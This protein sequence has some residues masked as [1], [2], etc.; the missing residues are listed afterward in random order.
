MS[1]NKLRKITLKM[2]LFR[3][4]LP[5]SLIFVMIITIKAVNHRKKLTSQGIIV[6]LLNSKE[7]S[8]INESD[9]Y[10]KIT[11]FEPGLLLGENTSDIN[12]EL[13]ELF[14]KE[15]ESIQKAEV[16]IDAQNRI[17]VNIVS[18]E[19]IVRILP[20][21]GESY[22]MDAK[23]SKIPLSKLY[24]TRVPVVTGHIDPHFDG[25]I[26]YEQHNLKLVFALVQ[27]IT[28]DEFLSSM[29]EQIHIENNGDFILIPKVGQQK[30]IFGQADARMDEKINQLKTFYLEAMP[31]KGW[32][33][34]QEIN[35]KY[36]GQI[37][38]TKS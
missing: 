18:K 37:V 14:L 13:I 31:K 32:N 10:D 9:I 19:P 17:N 33:T 38:C 2:V 23:G 21:E 1:T 3:L 15:D 4:G 28:N 16:F 24:T 22:Y 8:L 27:K 6:Q 12:L 34:Y 20:N 29:I 11:D 5:L 25:F 30:I 35:L 36:K 26:A 7:K